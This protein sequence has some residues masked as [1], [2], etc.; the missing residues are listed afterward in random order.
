MKKFSW[1]L[2]LLFSWQLM[3]CA[4]E[5]SNV[6]VAIATSPLPLIPA[7]AISCL[8]TKNAGGD[9]ATADIA[10]SYFKV[11][12][13]TFNRKDSAKIL[14]IAFVRIKIQIPGAAAPV[15][16]EVGGDGLA[17]LSQTWWANGAKEASIPAGTSTYSTDCPLYCGGIL[18]E[19]PYTASGTLEVFGLERDATTLEESPVKVQTAITIQSF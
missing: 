17:A 7:T 12:K 4:N 14:V 18:A 3:S 10:P 11:P 19:T 15:S 13:L 2:I 1:L 16:C 8:A 6:E 9:V 5:E